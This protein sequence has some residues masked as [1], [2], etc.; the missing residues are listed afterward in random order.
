MKIFIVQGAL[1]GVI[2]TLIGV[3][4]G[5]LLALNIDV[6]VPFLERLFSVQFLSREVYYISDLPSDLR[7]GDVLAIAAGV[8]GAFACWRRCTRAGAP[9]ASI[10]PRRCAMSDAGAAVLACRS[11]RKIYYQGRTPVEV[12]LG[13]DLVIAQGELVAIVGASGSG[14]STLLHLLGGL[15]APA[16]AKSTSW[17][18]RCTLSRTPSAAELRNR[19]ARLRLPVP[20]PA[21]GVHGAGERRH[22]APDPPHGAR[23]GARSRSGDAARGRFGRAP[24]AHAGRTVRRRAPARGAGARAGDRARLRARRRADRQPRPAQPPTACSS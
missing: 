14:K 4:G 5:V 24:R 10:P 13:V 19:F 15:D 21:A 3:G 6:V 8:A 12:L 11:L 9:R 16:A 17:A 7:Q 20:S 2:G 1:I 18:G 22:A 23:R